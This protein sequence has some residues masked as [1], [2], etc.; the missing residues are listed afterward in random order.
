MRTKETIRKKSIEKEFAE[1]VI[2][3][4]PAEV[5]KIILFGSR[6]KGV[7]A[8][9]SDY[10]LLVVLKR[11]DRGVIDGLYDEVMSFLERYEVDI[12][13]KIYTEDTFNKTMSLPTPFMAQIKKTGR[14]L[15]SVP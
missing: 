14:E 15:W 11:K 6:A 2:K 8:P 9:G 13:L 10:D 1:T 5:L 7:A 12:S 3:R 4:F